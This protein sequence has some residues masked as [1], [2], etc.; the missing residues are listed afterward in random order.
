MEVTEVPVFTHPMATAFKFPAVW[1][2]VNGTVIVVV[3]VEAIAV[4]DCTNVCANP[5]DDKVIRMQN[6]TAFLRE[7]FMRSPGLIYGDFGLV[8]IARLSA[9]GIL[10]CRYIVVCLSSYYAGINIRKSWRGSQLY[11]RTAGDTGSVY[12]ES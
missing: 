10:S 2:L 7:F 3:D 9:G 5:N 1:A 4:F 6:I 11:I 8:R 12:I